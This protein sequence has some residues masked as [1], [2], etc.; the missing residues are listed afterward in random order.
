MR[1]PKYW[2]F[3]FSISLSNEHPGLISFKMNWLDLKG[4]LK[5]L[6]HHTSKASILRRSAF[7]T[8]QFS[9]P[10]MTTGKTI[11]LTSIYYIPNAVT[12]LALTSI[13]YI[14]NA[15]KTLPLLL[16]KHFYHPKIKSC[17]H[18]KWLVLNLPCLQPLVTINLLFPV[19][20]LPTV[21]ETLV[22]SLG[23]ENPLEKGMAPP[24]F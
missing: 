14:P 23:R 18:T 4:T 20:N 15:V 11:A 3:S 16:S 9:N 22:L 2:S 17:T 12:M 13:Y 19:K 10:Y 8:V 1:W 5:S 6:Q 24:I 7:F 21:Q